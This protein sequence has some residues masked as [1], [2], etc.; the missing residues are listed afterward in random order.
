MSTEGTNNDEQSHPWSAPSVAVGFSYGEDERAAEEAAIEE[1]AG[2]APSSFDDAPSD[3][4]LSASGGSIFDTPLETV[5][6]EPGMIGSADGVE[7][8][9]VDGV[10]LSGDAGSL[11]MADVEN[12]APGASDESL[13]ASAQGA[14]GDPDVEAP[15]DQEPADAAAEAPDASSS[16]STEVPSE[17]SAA[18]GP[19]RREAQPHLRKPAKASNGS[20]PSLGVSYKTRAV[21]SF[22]VIAL[23]TVGFSMGMVAFIWNQFFSTYAAANIENLAE[24]TA[25]R[26]MALYERTLSLEGDTL[27]PAIE[28]ADSSDELGVVVSDAGGNTLYNSSDG[29]SGRDS[30][31]D[32]PSA[33]TQIAMAPIEYGGETVGN[34]R[35]WVYGSNALMSKVD[36]EFQRDTYMA[37][38][39]AGIISLACALVLGILFARALVRPVNRV[40]KA[41][42]ELSNGNLSARTG[43]D[44]TNEISR[45]GETLDE[46]A[47]SFERDRKME[48]RLT[49]DVAHE[50][51][52]PLMAIQ[53]TVE[54]MIDGVYERDDE[55]LMLVDA[56]VT[57]L[58]KLVDA[59][60]KLSR[61]EMRTQPMREEVV[62]LSA[63]ADD[64]VVSHE[65]F[66]EDSGLAIHL[67][68]QPGIKTIGDVD[69][70]KQAIA[71]LVSNA[72]RYTDEGGSITIS[73][74]RD[75]RM[76]AV[77]VEDTGIGLSPEEEKMVFSRFWRADSGRAKESG[78]LGVGLAL[79]KEIVDRHHG[80]V[81]AKGE[82]GV[83]SVFTLYFPL[84]DE[85]KSIAQARMAVRAME[86][87][88]RGGVLR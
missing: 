86:R 12:E 13:G 41:A 23:V 60:L 63:L 10:S 77:S 55:H 46:M 32:S 62:D 31:Q 73:V 28:A 84:Y 80:R 16:A 61:M 3:A 57:R 54:A 82:K 53:A 67:D 68:A 11:A 83:G 21:I 66:I 33:A 18:P 45:L 15:A 36:R 7:A 29:D 6:H 24:Q 75:G 72:V 43:M 87:R 48:Q 65:A 37:L 4:S 88:Q 56:E 17:A 1:V 26:M 85:E 22:V 30:V 34:V 71:N 76:A 27:I 38:I 49:S 44:G 81:S 19:K 20:K 51:R 79:V 59:L 39:Y 78:G 42:R 47:A 50:L 8:P 52:T 40:T 5:A 58:S 9:A 14:V 74:A 70:I 69:L 25:N 35:V 2:E 64:V